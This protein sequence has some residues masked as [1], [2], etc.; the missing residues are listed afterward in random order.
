ME[1]AFIYGESL[2][3]ATVPDENMHYRFHLPEVMAQYPTDRLVEPVMHVLVRHR[4]LQQGISV[5]KRTLHNER[6]LA[7]FYLI[8]HIRTRTSIYF[9]ALF[10]ALCADL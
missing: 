6:L 9:L 4:G 10:V 1:R 7:S 5:N 8:Y 2:L 3:K